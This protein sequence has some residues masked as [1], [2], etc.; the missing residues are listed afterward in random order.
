MIRSN[1]RVA[2]CES[3]HPVRTVL[4]PRVLRLTL[5]RPIQPKPGW[6][7]LNFVSAR[8]LER[9]SSRSTFFLGI[10]LLGVLG[11]LAGLWLRIVQEPDGR[12]V[13]RLRQA[14]LCC[15]SIY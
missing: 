9:D 6:L 3:S 10:G 14:L 2:K 1:V 7:F 8:F 11:L 13:C 5:F 12:C 4:N 15:R